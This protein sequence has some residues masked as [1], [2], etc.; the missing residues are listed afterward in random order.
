M[1]IRRIF[2]LIIISIFVL[3][4]PIIGESQK[5][6]SIK[7]H[8]L[9][10]EFNA[11]VHEMRVVDKILLSDTWN[12]NSSFIAKINPLFVIS[13]IYSREGKPIAYKYQ[14]GKLEI[15]NLAKTKRFT[16]EYSGILN[17]D[18]RSDPFAKVAVCFI[19]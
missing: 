9:R 7:A 14:D 6:Y 11:D 4:N 18:L 10:I 19:F 1:K 12:E 3:K 16:V 2:I 17:A 15:P 13:S 5:P 8:D